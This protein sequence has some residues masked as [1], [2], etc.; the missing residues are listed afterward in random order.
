MGNCCSCDALGFGFFQKEEQPTPAPAF[1]NQKKG[2]RPSRPEA[3]TVY[4][5]VSPA[6][7]S[8]LVESEAVE[9]REEAERE[10]RHERGYQEEAA[11]SSRDRGSA[12][13]VRASSGP[14]RAVVGVRQRPGSSSSTVLYT[15][16]SGEAAKPLPLPEKTLGEALLEQ[17]RERERRERERTP[18]KLHLHYGDNATITSPPGEAI[19]EESAW[20]PGRDLKQQQNPTS[21]QLQPPSQPPAAPASFPSTPVESGL[22]ADWSGALGADVASSPSSAGNQAFSGDTY[23][24]RTGATARSAPVLGGGVEGW[25]GGRG[26]SLDG[27]D[28]N[29]APS[30]DCNNTSPWKEHVSHEAPTSALAPYA[31][32]DLTFSRVLFTAALN[33]KLY[34]G[35]DV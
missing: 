22:L 26:G 13:H 18:L 32:G 21:S 33:S 1:H 30:K 27:T 3:Q 2:S 12:A 10:R 16:G 8:S 34:W 14:R 20:G 28:D 5:T 29:M 11:S 17:E 31:A 19:L 7:I 15:K 25:R 6:N 23:S 24:V 9:E 35:T 4:T